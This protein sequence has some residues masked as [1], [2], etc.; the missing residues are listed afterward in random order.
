MTPMK[1]ALITGITGQDG[2]YLTDTT[3]TDTVIY[4]ENIRR[5]RIDGDQQP[6]DTRSQDVLYINNTEGI[7][8]LPEKIW[9]TTANNSIVDTYG[10]WFN[11]KYT[12]YIN[13][14]NVITGDT[15]IDKT[16]TVTTGPATPINWQE[17]QVSEVTGNP[18]IQM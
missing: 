7:S 11:A 5:I 16:V 4:T 18:S 10:L 13:A 8:I 9:T 6:N 14:Y 1:K 15:I 3:G 17:A 2:S 12:Y